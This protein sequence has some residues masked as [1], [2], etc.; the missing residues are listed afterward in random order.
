MSQIPFVNQLGQ[1]IETAISPESMPSLSLV[2]SADGA[3][4]AAVSFPTGARAC[5]WPRS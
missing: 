4:G 2:G 3:R 1:A 5:Y